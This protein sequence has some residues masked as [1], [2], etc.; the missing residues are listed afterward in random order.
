MGGRF[1]VDKKIIGGEIMNIINMKISELK[2]Y[3]NNP[4]LI[5]DEAV[6]KVAA[7]IKEFGFKVPI[8]VDEENV[9]VA[10]HTRKLAAQSIG[11][12]EVP[13]V[14]ADDLTEEQIKAFRLADN[15]VS[16]FSDWDIGMLEEEIND[17]IG[18]DFDM[19]QFGFEI[20]RK[21]EESNKGDDEEVKPEVEFTTELGEESNY[22]VL[23]F[24]NSV[25]WLQLQSVFDLKRV[26]ALDSKDGYEKIGTGRVV[27][28]IEFLEEVRGNRD[29]IF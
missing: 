2:E 15:K 29:G 12:D 6:D 24:D 5:N 4:R 21:L 11:M 10:G 14:I 22:I 3:E 7:S 19:E 23:S 28:G 13:V 26:K 8:I 18:D 9:I 25:D 27:D 16:E 1:E 20:T 17:L